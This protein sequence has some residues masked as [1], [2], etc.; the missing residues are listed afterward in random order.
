[1]GVF[2]PNPSEMVM[3]AGFFS[4]ASK[5]LGTPITILPT[6]NFPTEDLQGDPVAQWGTP[7]PVN[8]MFDVRPNRRTLDGF[9]WF[10]ED[11]DILPILLYLPQYDLLGN[12]ITLIQ[13]SR[14]Q[15]END[16][17]SAITTKEFEIHK[18]TTTG[19]PGFYWVCWITPSRSVT[20]YVNPNTSSNFNYLNFNG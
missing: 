13:D 8:G 19:I 18:Y 4:E 5:F 20:P 15:V 3:L 6:V 14:I 17:D 11:P 12:N 7:I 10:A 2:D 9:G 16:I 1:M